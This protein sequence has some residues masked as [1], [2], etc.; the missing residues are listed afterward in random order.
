VHG[1]HQGNKIGALEEHK[2]AGKGSKRT[3]P[4]LV[5]FICL[6]SMRCWRGENHKAAIFPEQSKK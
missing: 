2:K 1:S 4:T 3:E 5:D 6:I